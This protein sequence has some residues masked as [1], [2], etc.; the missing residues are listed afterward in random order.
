MAVSQHADDK[1][2]HELKQHRA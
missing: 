1:E 2:I